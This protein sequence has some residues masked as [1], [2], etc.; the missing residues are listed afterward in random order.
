M[1]GSSPQP[2]AYRFVPVQPR[3][4]QQGCGPQIALL[5]LLHFFLADSVEQLVL[6]LLALLLGGRSR[7]VRVADGDRR[8]T[9]GVKADRGLASRQER[10]LRSHRRHPHLRP[11]HGPRSSRLHRR[12]IRRRRRHHRLRRSRHPGYRP[13]HRR[14]T[15]RG[16]RCRIPQSRHFPKRPQSPVLHLRPAGGELPEEPG[17]PAAPPAPPPSVPLLSGPPAPPPPAATIRREP[18]DAGPGA[19][20]MVRTSEAPPP[21]APPRP[22]PAPPPLPP[23]L[24]PPAPPFR[25][26]GDAGAPFPP[27]P[28]TSTK[29]TWPGVT[30]ISA[31]A[32]P[33][34][35]PGT[36]AVDPPR[37]P[38]AL[39]CSD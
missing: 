39:T 21:P 10:K 32:S 35:P 2:S 5:R 4:P 34:S 22:K 6:L 19:S 38:I 29:S 37:A 30:A 16:R 31:T 23:P 1:E 7:R 11:F 36:D 27:T 33:P 25:R 26:S 17:I 14:Q 12:T 20:C 13:R 18:S 3:A 28:P 15:R 8:D 24:N 9:N